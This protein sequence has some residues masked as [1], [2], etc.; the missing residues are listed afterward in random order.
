MLKIAGVYEY[1]DAVAYGNKV[2]R[3]KPFPDIFQKAADDLG[4]PIGECLVLE[5]VSYT[6]LDVYKRQLLDRQT[7]CC[8]KLS[9]DICT[10]IK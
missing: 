1:F 9:A 3:S 6:H 7:C 4:V 5:A 8:F 2:K 10:I